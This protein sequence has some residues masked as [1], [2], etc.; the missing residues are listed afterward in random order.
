MLRDIPLGLTED[1]I[2]EEV[3]N[4]NGRAIKFKNG[5]MICTHDV[6]I[7]PV[8]TASGNVFRSTSAAFWDFPEAFIAEPQVTANLKGSSF[9]WVGCSSTLTQSQLTG[10][11]S[12]SLGGTATCAAL[13]IGFWK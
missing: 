12:A 1:G 9:A 4:A 8:T 7:N 11:R 13:A 10:W 6:T 5:L 2:E 3:V